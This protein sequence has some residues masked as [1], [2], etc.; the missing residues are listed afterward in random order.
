MAH[1]LR[2]LWLVVTAAALLGAKPSGAVAS[3]VVLVPAGPDDTFE[4][5][6]VELRGAAA[7]DVTVTY[8]AAVLPGRP[9]RS[10]PCSRA[11]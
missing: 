3:T 11:R 9:P 5:R 10:G 1:A 6:G 8:D 7:I 4:L 2:G